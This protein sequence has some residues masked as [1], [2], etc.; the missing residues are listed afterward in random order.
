MINRRIAIS[1]MS[2]LAALSLMT[3]AT[4]AYFSSSATSTNNTFSSGTLVLA[5]TDTTETDMAAV[6]ASFG[7]TNMAPGT[8]TGDQ[9]LTLDNIGTVVANHLEIAASNT[10]SA[11]A[12]K[13]RIKKFMFDGTDLLN[14]IIGTTAGDPALKDLSDL[15]TAG[16]D[17]IGMSDLNDH[18]ITMDV[19][20]DESAPD[21]L[22]GS[23]NTLNLTFALNQHVSQ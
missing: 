16:Y 1:S 5:L 22:Q 6:Q 8:C 10:D 13:L 23:T 15:A 4:F 7:A 21:S 11:M 12:G 3:G 17:D 14:G 20:L 9:V 18:T 19:C 2:I